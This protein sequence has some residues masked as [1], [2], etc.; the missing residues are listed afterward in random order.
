MPELPEVET[1]VRDLSKKVRN[2]TFVDVWTDWRKMIKKPKSFGRFKKEIKN[3][4][5]KRIWRRA[6][7]IIID[8]SGGKTLLI[9]QKMTGHMLLGRWKMK[10]GKWQ[11]SDRGP[12]NDPV[13]RFIHLIFR[14]DDGKQLA[15]SDMRKFAKIEL[16]DSE[17]LK[18]S[19][20]F[21]RLGA[22][23]LD[24]T[25]TFKE[26]KDSL[27]QRG[28]IKQV[29]MDQN[30]VAGIGNIYSDEILWYARINP[31]RPVNEIKERDLRRI[32]GAIPIILRRAIKAR[33]DSMRDYRLINGGKGK[34]QEVEKVYSRE[35]KP[36]LRKD[37]GMIKR[38][39]IG[40]RSAH[41]CPECQK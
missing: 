20:E 34:Y 1:I 18:K 24:K 16:W 27:P 39:K 37:G 26:F 5:I 36:C 29:L 28:K 7:N 17:G 2:R 21:G 41:F 8:L 10:D 14:L 40:G 9:H 25:F 33:G 19:K 4:K 22:E 3:K 15:L 12:L 6:K 13:N 31:L 32:H 35:G 30:V 11:P 23:P 38:V